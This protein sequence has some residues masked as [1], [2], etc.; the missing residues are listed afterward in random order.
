[1]EI[2][3]Y[4]KILTDTAGRYL[5]RYTEKVNGETWVCGHEYYGDEESHED[6]KEMLIE[7]AKRGF[8]KELH[9]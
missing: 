1:M 2:Y 6:V 8:P 3:G 7:K 9:G 5:A 4:K